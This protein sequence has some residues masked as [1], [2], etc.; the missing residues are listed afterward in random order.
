ME[1][2]PIETAPRDGTHILVYGPC[3]DGDRQF[4]MEYENEISTVYFY[5]DDDH[6]FFVLSNVEY[7]DFPWEP[8]H[9]MSLPDPPKII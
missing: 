2:Q 1:W 5:G 7:A 9:W 8:T 6:D 3:V 4:R